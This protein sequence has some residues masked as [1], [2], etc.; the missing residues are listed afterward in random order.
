VQAGTPSS[1]WLEAVLREYSPPHHPCEVVLSQEI[2]RAA[3]DDLNSA[4]NRL[5]AVVQR[6]AGAEWVGEPD[7]E[8]RYVLFVP[9]A[10]GDFGHTFSSLVERGGITSLV[11]G[12]LVARSAHRKYARLWVSL[13]GLEEM[14]LVHEFG[15]LIGLVG[16]PRHERGAPARPHHCVSLTCA[17]ALPTVRVIARN[18]VM[19]I[20]NRFPVDYCSECQADI[21]KAQAYWRERAVEGGDY[22]EHRQRERRAQN[23]ML[24]V[25]GLAGSRKF[26]EMLDRVR[27]LRSVWPESE[28]WDDLESQALIGLGRAQEAIRL[29]YRQL[30]V[31]PSRSSYWKSRCALGRLYIGMGRYDDAIALFDHTSLEEAPEADFEQCVFILEQALVSCRRYDAAIALIDQLLKR[32]QPL[33][34]VPDAMRARHAELL[35]RSGRIQRAD[36]EISM[37]LR[38]RGLPGYWLEQAARLRQAQGRMNEAAQ[39]WR[40]FLRQSDAALGSTHDAQT[41]ES[42]CWSAVL[43]LARLGR[44]AEARARV[45]ALTSSPA[46]AA[47]AGDRVWAEIRA[48]AALGDWDRIAELVR[49]VSLSEWSSND[50][51]QIEDLGPMREMVEYHDL[52]RLC[53]SQLA[54]TPAAR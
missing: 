19:G 50:P 30:P 14:T 45:S 39:L 53:P 37:A 12:V 41:R 3:W 5:D 48:R 22:R 44:T 8:W 4:P 20:F 1:S 11:T 25:Q 6:Y 33:S 23:A 35:R 2:P 7:T 21:R 54:A 15:H 52:F 36:E 28:G 10:G 34:Y 38:D 16:N 24:S 18:L 32:N 17:M 47:A 13:D 29:L 40:E 46:E 49:T 51:C 9:D 42:L 31:D 27:E 26:G 43:C